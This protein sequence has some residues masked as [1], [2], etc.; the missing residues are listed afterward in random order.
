MLLKL[1]AQITA[2]RWEQVINFCLNGRIMKTININNE[3]SNF[4]ISDFSKG[5]YFVRIQNQNT[6]T[7][8]KII[9]K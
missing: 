7:I 4:N 2:M 1:F 3:D 6:T 5:I 9:K 8:N